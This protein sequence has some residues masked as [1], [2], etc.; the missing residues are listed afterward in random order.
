M[1]L[2]R[3]WPQGYGA[4]KPLAARACLAAGEVRNAMSA[5]QGRDVEAEGLYQRA[6]ALVDASLG[7]V[8]NAP[9]TQRVLINFAGLLLKQGRY[10]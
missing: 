3:A 8:E 5:R 6:L 10:K 7:G 2:C 1:Q 4:S 9:H